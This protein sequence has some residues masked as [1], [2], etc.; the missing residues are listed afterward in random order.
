MNS[1]FI[2]S[3]KI[4]MSLS[5]ITLFVIAC[6]NGDDNSTPL[7]VNFGT[8]PDASLLSTGTVEVITENTVR[9]HVLNFNAGGYT[10]TI[11]ET[12]TTATLIDVGIQGIEGP[13]IR[14]YANALGKTL[15]V[16]IT[17]DHPD[18]YGNIGSFTDIPVYAHLEAAA[19]LAVNTGFTD[20]YSTAINVVNDSQT[21]GDLEFRF[22]N[23]PNA[24]TAENGYVFIPSVGSL[25]PGDLVYNGRHNYIR[26]Y[27]PLDSVDELDNWITGLNQL[28]TDFGNYNHIFV[29]HVGMRTD[30]STVIDE[31][32]AYLSD[33]QGLIKGTKEL[34]SGGFATSVQDVVDELALLYPDLITGAL[35]FA[36]PDAFFPGDPGANWFN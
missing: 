1:K 23:I 27:T 19:D 16:I 24:E 11:V 26:E 20:L 31:N 17:H 36:L 8:A 13:E 30:I 18:H 5:L 28:K 22:A 34:T 14:S 33:A 7:V 29:G 15:S 35:I 2:K 9:Y 3:L 6:N 12:E 10:S 25:F 32:I 21:I 4:I